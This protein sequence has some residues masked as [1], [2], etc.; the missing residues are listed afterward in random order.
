VLEPK[1][2]GFRAIAC[3]DEDGGPRLYT[4]RGRAHHDRFPRLNAELRELPARTVLDGE[5]VCLEPIEGH[6]GFGVASIVSAASW[7]PGRRTAHPA[8]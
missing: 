1:W 4:R 7:S 5:L 3:V 6:P 2:D 8:G